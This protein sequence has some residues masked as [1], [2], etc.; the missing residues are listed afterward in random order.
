MG[1]IRQAI[2]RLAKA[3]K[4]WGI[5]YGPAAAFVLSCWRLG[6]Q[7]ISAVVVITDEGRELNL[8]LDPPAVVLKQCGMAV[9]RWRWKRIE[10]AYPHLA[11][12]GSGRGALMEPIWQLLKDRKGG[13]EW[14]NHHK[15]ALK[16]QMAGRQWTQ[17]RVHKAGWSQHN[18]CIACLSSIVD[19]ESPPATRRSERCGMKWW[20]PMS[21]LR[22]HLL[23]TAAIAFGLVNAMRP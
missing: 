20:Q 22:G 19:S 7:V 18:K 9:Q 12:N 8:V 6:W 17:T 16:S 5:A 13:S 14:N 3:K 23:G 11:A 10:K 2:V 21:R 1:M 4:Q 15:G